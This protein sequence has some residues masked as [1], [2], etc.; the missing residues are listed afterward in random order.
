MRHGAK[1]CTFH[2]LASPM[3]VNG[4]TA[5]YGWSRWLVGWLVHWLVGWLVYWLIGVTAV[6]R[7]MDLAVWWHPM[8]VRTKE[9]LMLVKK[10]VKVEWTTEME[11]GTLANGKAIR[12]DE[13]MFESLS[14]ELIN[15]NERD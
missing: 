15:K 3:S 8:D 9:T 13:H 11:T 10:T 1:E 6:A 12:Y 2:Q 4:R 14:F 5:R 7:C